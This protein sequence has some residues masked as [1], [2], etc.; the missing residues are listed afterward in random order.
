MIVA[1]DFDG[2][3]AADDATFP[4]IGTINYPMVKLVQSLEEDGHEV[5]L[6]TSRT[7]KAL[8]SALTWCHYLGL[9][10]CAINDNA[11]SN[12][13]KYSAAYPQG[14]RKV[15]ADIYIDDHNPEFILNR[16]RYGYNAAIDVMINQ[17]KEIT[18][19]WEKGN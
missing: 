10:F 6:W 8:S 7:G 19:L 9:K 18:R 11:P 14:T 17:V 15:H 12:K 5:V 2:I 1:V 4:D 16:E 13:A 3:L